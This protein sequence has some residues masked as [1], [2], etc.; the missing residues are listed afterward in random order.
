MSDIE[1]LH[2]KP[3]MGPLI[4]ATVGIPI[5]QSAANS[6]ALFAFKTAVIC[7]HMRR[8]YPVRFFSR[9]VRHR[10]KDTLEVPAT[11]E[12][13]FAAFAWPGQGACLTVYHDVPEPDS[14]KLYVCTYLIGHLVFQVVASRKPVS[15][16]IRPH[17]AT[18][19]NLAV[20]FWPRIRDGFIWPAK[21]GLTTA[22]EFREFATRWNR[23]D[24]IKINR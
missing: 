1:S 23:I 21:S 18:F 12:M 2:A 8:D 7:D 22:T 20:P 15:W 14:L 10:F 11:V 24:C 16:H 5:T 13:W 9:E 19:E 6:I 4:D 17:G 3:V